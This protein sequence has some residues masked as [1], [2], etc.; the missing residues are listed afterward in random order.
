MNREHNGQKKYDKRTNNDL[1]NIV[2]KNKERQQEHNKTPGMNSV[3]LEWCA[4]PHP[5]VAPIILLLYI[6]NIMYD[7]SVAPIILLL[8]IMTMDLFQNCS[9]YLAHVDKGVPSHR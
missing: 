4:C 6:M 7:P 3:V 1:Q 2:Q 5:S 9:P 8:Y